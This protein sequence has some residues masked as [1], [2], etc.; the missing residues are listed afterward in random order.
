MDFYGYLLQKMG[1]QVSPIGYFYVC[2]AKKDLDGF[3]GQL[4]FEETLVPYEWD[5]SWIDGSLGEM[6]NI[7]LSS[8]LPESEPACENCAYAHQRAHAE[9]PSNMN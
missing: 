3:H 2:N 1:F 4:L 8:E 5:G 9:S 6:I 7:L